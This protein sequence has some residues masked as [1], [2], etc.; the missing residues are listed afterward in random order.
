MLPATER[1][2]VDFKKITQLRI[3]IT[4]THIEVT[5]YIDRNWNMHFPIPNPW[6]DFRTACELHGIVPERNWNCGKPKSRKVVTIAKI[7]KRKK[8]E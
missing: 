4:K 2:R 5:T 7:K 1:W 6:R 3:K 8:N